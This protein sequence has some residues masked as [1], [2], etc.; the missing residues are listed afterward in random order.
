LPYRSELDEIF[1]GSTADGRYA[2]D[3]NES[4]I[5]LSLIG[6]N[7]GPETLSVSQIPEKEENKI[8]FEI[9]TTSQSISNQF[10][11]PSD[12]FLSQIT[13]KTIPLKRAVL[14]SFRSD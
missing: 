2:Q 6:I 3:N 11:L 10:D 13:T 12:R 1:D 8:D 7:N 4:L 14:S 5:N 9:S